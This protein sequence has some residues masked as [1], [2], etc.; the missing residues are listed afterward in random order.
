[1]NVLQQILLNMGLTQVQT[2]I[3]SGN[4]IYQSEEQDPLLL[5]ERIRR[6]ILTHTEL[7]I[8]VLTLALDTFKTKIEQCPFTTVEEQNQLYFTFFYSPITSID[9]S[10]FTA[11]KQADELLCLLPSILYLVTPGGY[12]KTKLTTTFIEN[13]LGISTTTRNYKTCCKLIELAKK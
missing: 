10:V 11:K 1:M 4:L 8:P 2:Y 3:Q 12:G 6:A 7:D 9:Q 5:S 13:K